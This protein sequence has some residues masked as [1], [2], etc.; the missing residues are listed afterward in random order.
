[1]THV[2]DVIK[3]GGE[4]HATTV[5]TLDSKTVYAYNESNV[6]PGNNLMAD[7]FASYT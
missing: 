3:R 1:M 4:L 6:E 7:E 5:R 2:I